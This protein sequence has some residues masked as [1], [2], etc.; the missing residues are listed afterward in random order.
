MPIIAQNEIQFL[1]HINTLNKDDFIETL[2]DIVDDGW[3]DWKDAVISTIRK[4]H[5]L[6]LPMPQYLSLLT[7]R[8]EK[9]L[10][11]FSKKYN[12]NSVQS[13]YNSL[14]DASAMTFF[15]L[16]FRAEVQGFIIK[17]DIW[18]WPP[19]TFSPDDSLLSQ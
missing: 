17:E 15:L 19:T 13:L 10:D 3:D 11:T 8:E 9:V 14:D 18:L 5:L 6:K 1:N 12:S 16:G 2:F 7:Q 4:A